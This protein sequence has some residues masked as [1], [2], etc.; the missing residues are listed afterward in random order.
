MPVTQ[1]SDVVVPSTFAPYVQQ[2]TL[3]LSALYRSGVIAPD[4]ELTAAAASGGDLVRLPF[5]NDL[6]GESNVGSDNPSVHSTPASINADQDIAVKH[7]RNKS[8]SSMSLAG[9]LAGSDPARVVADSIAEYW[10]RDMQSILIASL[11]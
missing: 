8:W 10:A 7:F 4:Q 1:I 2:K 5:W 6:E 9:E 11:T 3:E